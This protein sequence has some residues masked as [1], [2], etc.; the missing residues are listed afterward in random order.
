MTER[1]AVRTPSTLSLRR[2]SR[3]RHT[4]FQFVIRDIA[5]HDDIVISGFHYRSEAGARKA[6][7]KVIKTLA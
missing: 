1:Y 7:E 3:P 4:V 6:A 5:K 2:G